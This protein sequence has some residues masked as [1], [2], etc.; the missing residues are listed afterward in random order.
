MSVSTLTDDDAAE[1]TLSTWAYLTASLQ[2][3]QSKDVLDCVLPFVIA[4][5]RQQKPGQPLDDNAVLRFLA[6]IG[7]DL[8]EPVLTSLK[9]RLRE[10]AVLKDF[11]GA[12]LVGQPGPKGAGLP[13]LNPSLREVEKALRQFAAD[14]F[15]ELRPPCAANWKAALINV[16][17]SETTLAQVVQGVKATVTGNDIDSDAP[18]FERLIVGRFVEH[19]A[20]RRDE[21]GVYDTVLQVFSGLKILDFIRDIQTFSISGKVSLQVYYDTSILMR[22]LGMS[23]EQIQQATE[24]MHRSLQKI[25]CKTRY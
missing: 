13:D 21:S 2:T 25:G 22:L 9:P 19:C 4:G 14:Y 20:A 1:R 16:L 23:G 15:N 7:L 3:S 24:R 8:P 6:T 11:N 17:K 18:A 12:D 5:I 10:R